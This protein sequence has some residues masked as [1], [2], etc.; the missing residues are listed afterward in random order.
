[1]TPQPL[2]RQ[3]RCAECDVSVYGGGIRAFGRLFCSEECADDF[4]DDRGD[5]MGVDDMYPEWSG[6]MPTYVRGLDAF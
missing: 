3:R 2:S 4:E 6:S 1:M 5:P